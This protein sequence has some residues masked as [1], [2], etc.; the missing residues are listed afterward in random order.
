V[1]MITKHLVP[2]VAGNFLSKKRRKTQSHGFRVKYKKSFNPLCVKNDISKTVVFRFK[3]ALFSS[4][5]KMKFFL[6]HFTI[7]H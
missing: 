1:N 3:N 7:S 6:S 5:S 2:K 4:V